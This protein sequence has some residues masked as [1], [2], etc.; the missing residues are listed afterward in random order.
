MKWNE[1][2]NEVPEG[3]HAF[4]GASRYS[5]INYDEDRLQEAYRSYWAVHR[6]TVLHDFASRCI[7]LGQPLPE[8]Q[9]TL[10]MFVN[11]AIAYRMRSEQPLYYSANCF[12]TADAIS[13]FRK[14]LRI[15]DLKTGVTPAHMEQLR[16]YAALFFLE[17]GYNPSE[18]QMEL[19]IYQNDEVVV[20]TP[21]DE[22]IVFIMNKIK[23]FDK[24][25]EKMKG[26]GYDKWA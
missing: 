3:A 7:K 24:V 13:Y 15:H 20:E 21:S 2:G 16:I 5:W 17:Y 8:I 12:G 19:R 26:A 25:V 18:T 9:Q 10:N 11:D 4:L 23:R 1:H 6:G 14:K 22:D